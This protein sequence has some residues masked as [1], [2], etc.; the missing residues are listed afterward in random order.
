[1]F[2]KNKE[3]MKDKILIVKI[4]LPCSFKLVNIISKK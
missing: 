1:M 3:L 4:A 2:P